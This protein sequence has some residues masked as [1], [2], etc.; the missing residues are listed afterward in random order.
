MKIWKISAVAA[1]IVVLMGS[2]AC[3]FGGQSPAEQQV[4][5]A[6]GDLTVTVNGNGKAAYA[7]DS[8]LTFGTAGKIEKLSVKE[9]DPVTKG[10][11]LAQL[12]TDTLELAL[13]QAQVGEAQ[14]QLA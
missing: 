8:E 2:A 4:A 1:A 13:S 10:M 9:G 5:I 14:A 11:V 3:S 6:K 7:N 12:E